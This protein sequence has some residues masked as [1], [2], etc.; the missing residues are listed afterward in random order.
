M[1][2]L[3]SLTDAAVEFVL[4]TTNS[5]NSQGALPEY[6]VIISCPN[7]GIT[8]A[9]VMPDT[10][11]LSTSANYGTPFS[12]LLDKIPGSDIAKKSASSFGYSLTT[13]ILSAKV[14]QG[15]SSTEFSLKLIFQ[16]ETDEIAEVIEP[17][18]KLHLLTTPRTD[19]EFG[20]LRAP[21][22]RFN[23]ATSLEGVLSSLGSAAGSAVDAVTGAFKSAFSDRGTLTN[24][25][26]SGVSSFMS[27]AS[28]AA[29]SMSAGLAQGVTNQISLQ[30]GKF[31]LFDSVII[32]D[33]NV[34]HILQPVGKDYGYSSGNMQRAEVTV[35]F[36]TFFNLTSDDI[37]KIWINPDARQLAMELVERVRINDTLR[38]S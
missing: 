15:T 23:A 22:P 21:G 7:L 3:S 9:A 17:V 6:T 11:D 10:F 25:V 33:V 24:A 4:P 38:N 37:G 12:D 8:L 19:S 32:K 27:G 26:Q 31:L 34:S 13:K 16:A 30:I 5:V 35:T 20:L 28:N 14:W 18:I 1:S 2:L 36:E 29:S